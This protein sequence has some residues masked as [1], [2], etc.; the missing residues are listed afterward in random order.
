MTIP[1]PAG[2]AAII[3]LGM[4]P[5]AMAETQPAVLLSPV[6]PTSIVGSGLNVNDLEAQKAWY[7][8]MLGM[9]VTATYRRGDAPFEYVMSLKGPGG[10]LALLKAPRPPGQNGFGRVILA[11]PDAKALAQD[12]AAHG[13]AMREV[14]PDV[15]YFITDP[16]GNAIELY[17]RPK[18]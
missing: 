9:S 5:G 13:V 14:I 12:L 4:T 1:I 15:A 17:T 2:L 8:A 18:P 7:M 11:S 3:L 6:A 16:E 10:V